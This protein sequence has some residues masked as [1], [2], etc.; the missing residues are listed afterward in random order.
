MSA[1]FKE[2]LKNGEGLYGRR[3]FK[4]LFFSDFCEIR[5][6][7]T[8]EILASCDTLFTTVENSLCIANF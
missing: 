4:I 5:K 1:D 7:W 2:I 8:T 6:V 3:L